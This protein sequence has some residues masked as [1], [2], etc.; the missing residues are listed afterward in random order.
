MPETIFVHG[1]GGFIGTHL[2]R[3]LAARDAPTVAVSRRKFE[4][5]AAIEAHVGELRDTAQ[6]RPFIA[7]CRTVVHLASTSTPGSTAGDPLA[8]LDANLRSTLALLHALQ[9]RP[10]VHLVYVSSGGNLYPAQTV[11]ATEA[12]PTTPRSYHGAA[13]AA[14]EQFVMAWCAQ[15]GARAT[16]LR[17]SNVYGP[18]QE[19]R[20]GFAIIPTAMRCALRGDPLTIWGDGSAVRDYLYIDD[21]IALC[22]AV[23][24]RPGPV[25]CR[26]LNASSGRPTRLD[27][28]LTEIEVVSGR[29][30]RR[31]YA[32]PRS[33]DASHV[34]IDSGAAARRHG[35]SASV[36]LH[37]GL[38]R[39]W[40][41]LNSRQG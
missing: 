33:V 11:A 14:A 34:E 10:D 12:L 32:A 23:L 41:W 13:K 5:P 7:R 26:I 22:L 21:F 24:D 6:F 3:S 18:G 31:E 8:E 28:L 35:W 9:A 36:D 15:F 2:L 37:E 1:A 20:A 25:G 40:A 4:P 19:E 16:I 39:T 38:S 27:D 29:P 17:P 30:L